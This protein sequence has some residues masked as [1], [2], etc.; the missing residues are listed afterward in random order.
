MSVSESRQH[1]GKQFELTDAQVRQ[2]ED[3]GIEK[4][5]PPLNE[6]VLMARLR[7]VAA[8]GGF[9]SGRAAA[10]RPA[11]TDSANSCAGSGNGVLAIT[12][13]KRSSWPAARVTK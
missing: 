7:S 6:A 13:A 5:W 12:V 10:A 11:C 2:I 4:E 9:A 1:I 3:E 8:V